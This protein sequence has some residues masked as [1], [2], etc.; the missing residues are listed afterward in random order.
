MTQSNIDYVAGATASPEKIAWMERFIPHP[1]GSALDL[2]CGAGLY[3][4]W[5][6]NKAWQ[7]QA[8]D[9]NQPPSIP[10]VKT[11]EHNLEKGLPF[12]DSQFDLVM[13]WDV[14]E[15]VSAEEALWRDLARVL[16]PGGILLGSVPHNADQRLRPYNLTFKHQIDKT[17][18]R[19]Y[20]R[21]DI[22]TR[23]RRNGLNPIQADLKGPV[24]PQVFAEFVS[25][26]PLRRPIA[27][28]IGAARRMGLL[29]FGELYADVFFAAG[30]PG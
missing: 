27:R 13:A 23:M 19:E 14:L 4:S 20:S 12:P 6:S 1:A 16:R 25:I 5:L 24:S 17:H 9:V 11:M 2:G 29:N 28:L 8:V 26:R 10:G 15:H 3:S 7:V 21:E 18:Q 22:E 30:K